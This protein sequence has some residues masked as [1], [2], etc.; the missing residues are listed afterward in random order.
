MRLGL[1]PIDFWKVKVPSHTTIKDKYLDSFIEGYANNIYQIPSGWGTQKCHTSFQEIRLIEEDILDEYVGIFNSLLR[2]CYTQ[3]QFDCWYQVY[4][5]S[6]Y[7]EWHEHS[8]STLSAI[9]FLKFDEEHKA[10]VFRDPNNK[11]NTYTPEVEE[12]DIII[13]PSYVQHCVPEAQYRNHR[14]TI[15]LNLNLTK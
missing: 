11:S 3:E 8:P 5:D 4:K 9:H 2:E 14:A 12:G 1:F 10:P 6:E 7:Q 15:A 13:F